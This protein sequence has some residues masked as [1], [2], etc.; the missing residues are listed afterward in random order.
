[1]TQYVRVRDK[2]T[3]HHYSIPRSRYDATPELWQLLKQ[4]AT[5][6]GG[7]PLPAKHHTS[8]SAE[9]DKKA[10]ESADTKKE[11]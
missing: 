3:S 9:A 7:D 6:A 11:S 2:D 8:V 10:G 1:M 4:P 5:D